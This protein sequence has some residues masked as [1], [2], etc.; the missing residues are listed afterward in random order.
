MGD[1]S[2]STVDI[3]ALVITFFG[4]YAQISA[5]SRVGRVLA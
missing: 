2:A 3:L 1:K 4:F 5:G